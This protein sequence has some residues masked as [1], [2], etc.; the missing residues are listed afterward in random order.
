MRRVNG[1]IVGINWGSSHFRAYRIAPD[2]RVLDA[3]EAPAGIATLD[4]DGMAA[5]MAEVAARWPDVVHRYAAGMIG[6][7]IGWS[8]AGYVECPAAPGDVHA[9]LHRVRIGGTEVDIVPGLASRRADGAPDVLRGEETELFGLMAS[10]DL[11]PR[12]LV[13]L[14]GTH[15][16]WV[17]IE[18]GRV[19]EFLTCMSGELYDRLTAQGLLAS[20]VEGEAHA[21]EAFAQGVR[22]GSARALGLSSLLFGARARVLRGDLARADAASH[23]RGVLIGAE[24]ADARATFPSFGEQA[25]P[26]IGSAPVRVLYRA[27]LAEFGIETRMVDARDAV[28]RG[29]LAL[30]A[31]RTAAAA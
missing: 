17:R 18:H 5:R 19:A 30:H 24:L 16:K 12:G 6:S 9:A 2:G 28:S 3:V 25:I 14:P 1:D 27:A 21:G 29:F 31:A 26:L 11:A 4:R 22:L 15:T 13:A 20:I 23:L 10:G 8:D 7:N